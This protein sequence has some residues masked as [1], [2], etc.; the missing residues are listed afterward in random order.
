MLAN[1]RSKDGAAGVEAFKN[2]VVIKSHPIA[3]AQNA[4]GSIS[5]SRLHTLKLTSVMLLAP[6]YYNGVR[7]QVVQHRLLPDSK[8]PGE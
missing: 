4:S 6:I 8:L 1:E 3:S 7:Y 2:D 5:I